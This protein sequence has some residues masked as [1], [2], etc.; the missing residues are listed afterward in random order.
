MPCL[1]AGEVPDFNVEDFVNRKD[2]K[3]IFD[4]KRSVTSVL[5]NMELG[6]D[7]ILEGKI[8]RNKYFDRLEFLVNNVKNFDIKNEIEMLI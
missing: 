6:K 3:N 1:I 2:A 5:E 8:R 7:I 4:E